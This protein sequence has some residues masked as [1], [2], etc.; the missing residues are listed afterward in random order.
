[1]QTVTVNLY[2]FDELSDKAKGKALQELHTTAEYPWHN[3]NNQ[4]LK[5]IE[6]TFKLER[7]DWGYDVFG[8]WFRFEVPHN[9]KQGLNRKKLS[10]WLEIMQ[11]DGYDLT[12]D[13]VQCFWESFSQHG[14]IKQSLHDAIG[15]V[16]KTCQKDME[17]YFS[18][19]SLVDHAMSNEYEFTEDGSLA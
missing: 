15:S 3:E 5:A 14:D 12:D 10:L 8:S 4:T 11:E 9:I 18:E 19:E 6:R 16:V 1:M 17:G 7:F 2:Q 13:F